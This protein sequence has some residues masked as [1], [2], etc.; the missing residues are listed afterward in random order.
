MVVVAKKLLEVRVW[1]V[2]DTV[3]PSFSPHRQYGCIVLA[4]L[5]RTEIAAIVHQKN[6]N[7]EGAEGGGG[8]K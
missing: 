4:V 2:V 7:E 3:D 8:C 6:R 1:P 5:R